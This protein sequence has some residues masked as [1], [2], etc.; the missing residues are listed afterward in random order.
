MFG[1]RRK[2]LELE[3]RVRKLEERVRKLEAEYGKDLWESN[4]VETFEYGWVSVKRMIR[5]LATH[6]HEEE[7]K[8][9]KNKKP[10]YEQVPELIAHTFGEPDKVLYGKFEEET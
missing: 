4:M 6:L 9:G 8:N 5:E 1:N 3:E 10:D 2:L 7:I